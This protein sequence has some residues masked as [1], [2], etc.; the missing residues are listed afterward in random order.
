MNPI[1]RALRQHNVW[2]RIVPSFYHAYP[3]P[4]GGQVYIDITES[5][6]MFDRIVGKDERNKHRALEHFLGQ[7][8]AY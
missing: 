4:T 8:D 7:G 5:P 1:S 2:S 3:L 6:M